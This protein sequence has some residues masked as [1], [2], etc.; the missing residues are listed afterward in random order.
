MTPQE[1]DLLEA[2]TTGNLSKVT[3]LCSN[4]IDLNVTGPR[5]VTPLFFASM[6]VLNI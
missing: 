6:Q 3:S 4:K 1:R 5:G 2:C